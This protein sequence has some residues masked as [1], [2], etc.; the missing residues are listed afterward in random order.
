MR[1]R[2]RAGHIDGNGYSRRQS[3]DKTTNAA[4]RGKSG[5][6]FLFECAMGKRGLKRSMSREIAQALHTRTRIPGF[7]QMTDFNRKQDAQ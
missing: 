6:Q 1:R 3:R 7:P 5:E 4:L 2:V